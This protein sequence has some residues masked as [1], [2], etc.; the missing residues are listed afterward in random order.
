MRLKASF[1]NKDGALYPNQFVNARLLVRTLPGA[2]TVPAS[3]VQLGTRGSYVY[4][5]RQGEKGQDEAQLRLVT[6]GVS[7]GGLTVID[8]GLEAGEKVV[9]DGLDRLRDGTAV[10]VAATVET[11]RAESVNATAESGS[12]T[13]AGAAETAGSAGSPGPAGPA[14]PAGPTGPTGIG[15]SGQGQAPSSGSTPPAARHAP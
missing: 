5:V 15:G 14:G 6:P 7:S 8:K 10:R 11:P 1:A 2:V 9:V 12:S 3:A 4:V 13:A